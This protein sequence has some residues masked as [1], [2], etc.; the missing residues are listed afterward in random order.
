MT[1]RPIKLFHA[2]DGAMP[3]E[4]W[5][6]LGRQY[7]R[8]SFAGFYPR[9]DDYQFGNRLDFIRAGCRGKSCYVFRHHIIYSD[10]KMTEWIEIDALYFESP[11]DAVEFRLRFG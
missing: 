3:V 4:Q 9:T 1:A 5:A 10:D 6:E 8:W 2:H 7:E 11:V